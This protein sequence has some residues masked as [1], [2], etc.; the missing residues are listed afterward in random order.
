MDTNMTVFKTIFGSIFMFGRKVEFRRWKWNTLNRNTETE[1]V[2]ISYPYGQYK[3]REKHMER[4]S[5]I[6]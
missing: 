4:T 1:I 5:E 2:W 3:T 6:Y